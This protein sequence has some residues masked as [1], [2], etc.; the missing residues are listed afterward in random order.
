MVR[1]PFQFFPYYSLLNLM[2]PKQ[3]TVPLPKVYYKQTS[4][5][6]SPDYNAVYNFLQTQLILEKSAFKDP[7][8]PTS[9]HQ[10]LVIC[11]HV[12]PRSANVYSRR[13]GRGYRLAMAGCQFHN[14][15]RNDHSGITKRF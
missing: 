7:L 8:F 10:L 14:A 4:T 3:I 6:G 13:S 12:G 1:P 5:L 9:I 11:D 15:H 2:V